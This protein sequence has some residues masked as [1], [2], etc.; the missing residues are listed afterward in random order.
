MHDCINPPQ[1]I[2]MTNHS[3]I[4]IPQKLEHEYFN[5]RKNPYAGCGGFLQ[6][7]LW[8]H[9]W[10]P[11]VKIKHFFSCFIIQ[12]N[13]TDGN[14]RVSWNNIVF[15]IVVISAEREKTNFVDQR[16]TKISFGKCA[17]KCC[18]LCEKTITEDN[19]IEIFRNLYNLS[20]NNEQDIYPVK[21]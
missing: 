17:K 21:T 2:F 19:K 8:Q 15:F 14:G 11:A 10:Q 4:H 6:S 18:E 13:A 20:T 7:N 9:L 16:N 3:N 12:L 1:T 5:E